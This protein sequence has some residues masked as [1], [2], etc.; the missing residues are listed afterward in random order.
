[1]A[2]PNHKRIYYA[3]NVT[4]KEIHGGSGREI[5]VLL[6]CSVKTVFTYAN[7]EGIF[8]GHKISYVEEDTPGEFNSLT[9]EDLKKWDAFVKNIRRKPKGTL[10]KP[11]EIV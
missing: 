7:V 4:T 9:E 8:K 10:R 3:E 1:M 6:G 5:A 2:R 11:Q